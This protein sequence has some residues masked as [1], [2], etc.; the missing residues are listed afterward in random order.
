MTKREGMKGVEK[1][2]VRNITS[3]HVEGLEVN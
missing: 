1:K 2:A 3:N